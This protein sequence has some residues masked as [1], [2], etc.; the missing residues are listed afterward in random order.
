VNEPTRSPRTSLSRFLTWLGSHE[1]GVLFAIVGVATGVWAFAG[2]AEEVTEG[3]S[4]ALDR[5]VLLA[6]RNPER[7]PQ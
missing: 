5:K 3:D 4:Q 7:S 2:I 1:L 6:L